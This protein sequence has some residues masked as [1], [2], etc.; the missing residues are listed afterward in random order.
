[1]QK[2]TQGKAGRTSSL[3]VRAEGV[4]AKTAMDRHESPWDDH[5]TIRAA[6]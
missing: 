3:M 6:S 5:K 2:Q 1:M 4:V